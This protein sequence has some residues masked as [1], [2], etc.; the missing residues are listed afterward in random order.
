MRF[1]QLY[2]HLYFL[3]PP[4]TNFFSQT[5]HDAL[6]KHNQKESIGGRISNITSIYFPLLLREALAEILNKTCTRYNTAPDRRG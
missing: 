2:V 3:H 5:N 6:K 4:L 1:E